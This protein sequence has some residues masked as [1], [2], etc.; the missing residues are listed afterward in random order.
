[1]NDIVPFLI[2][3]EPPSSPRESASAEE[4]LIREVGENSVDY[5]LA[6]ERAERAAAKRAN[7]AAA[8]R[9][10]Q[11]LAIEYATLARGQAR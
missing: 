2:F 9:V 5:F 3:K 4:R 10:H 7:S 1:V 11:E 8:R 6:R